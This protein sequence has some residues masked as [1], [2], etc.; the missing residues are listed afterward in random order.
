M[1]I[2]S[3]VTQLIRDAPG[4]GVLR[5]TV[6]FELIY[7]LWVSQG[8]G[9]LGERPRQPA[10][11]WALGF[12]PLRTG[13]LAGRRRPWAVP[14]PSPVGPGAIARAKTWGSPPAG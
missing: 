14:R 10:G 3:K 8:I 1:R 4:G 2:L 6:L 9:I 7:E 13:T 11:V 12:D 5:N